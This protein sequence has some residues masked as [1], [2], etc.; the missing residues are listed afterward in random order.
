METFGVVARPKPPVGYT[1]VWINIY[2]YRQKRFQAG[3]SYKTRRKAD[4]VAKPYRHDC[5]YVF[6]KSKAN[7]NSV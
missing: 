3:G 6:V 1:G 2:N 7:E 5:V 4:N